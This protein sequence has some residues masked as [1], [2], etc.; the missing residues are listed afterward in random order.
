MMHRKIKKFGMEGQFLDDSLA[1][2]IK[3]INERTENLAKLSYEKI[4]SIK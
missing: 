3:D 4:W 1:G 2:S